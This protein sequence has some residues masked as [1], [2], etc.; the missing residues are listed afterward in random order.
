LISW[1][2]GGSSGPGALRGKTPVL[3]GDPWTMGGGNPVFSR[4]GGARGLFGPGTWVLAL[5]GAGPRVPVITALV[6]LGCNLFLTGRPPTSGRGKVLNAGNPLGPACQTQDRP[7]GGPPKRGT[8][9]LRNTS[10]FPGQAE[11]G[12]TGTFSANPFFEKKKPS[13]VVLA[14]PRPE[15]RVGQT[16]FPLAFTL[17]RRGGQVGGA[18]HTRFCL[19]GEGEKGIR[20]WGKGPFPK[21]GGE[22]GRGIFG[23]GGRDFS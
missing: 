14:G 22:R 16:D 13:A 12:Q 5:G 20:A 1:G 10:A 23:W 21:R 18:G 9:P 4:G 11:P 15:F 2:R 19:V 17:G 6:R 7:R 8:T 3:G